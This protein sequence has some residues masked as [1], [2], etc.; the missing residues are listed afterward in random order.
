MMPA[1]VH[2]PLDERIALRA[3]NLGEPI[4]M[5][6]GRTA[7]GQ[8]FTRLAELIH[9]RFEALKE[10]ESKESVPGRVGLGRLL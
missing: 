6:R 5:K 8:G 1:L 2:L 7:L 4:M 3:A 10:D 9:Q